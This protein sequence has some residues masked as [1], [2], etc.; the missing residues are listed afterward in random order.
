VRYDED[1]ENQ[2]LILRGQGLLKYLD[3]D[4]YQTPTSLTIENEI[5][6]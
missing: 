6:F 2:V 3:A 5:T 1:L 4:G